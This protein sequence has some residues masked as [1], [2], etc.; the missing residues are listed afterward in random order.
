[1]SLPRGIKTE[2]PPLGSMIIAEKNQ[3]NEQVRC[4]HPQGNSLTQPFRIGNLQ[5]LHKQRGSNQPVVLVGRKKPNKI[6]PGLLEMG[7]HL[8]MRQGKGQPDPHTTG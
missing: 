5:G 7:N 2:L 4:L 8:Q 1:M 6:A 3:Q